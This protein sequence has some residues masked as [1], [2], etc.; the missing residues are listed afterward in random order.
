[1]VSVQMQIT[2]Q[3]LSGLIFMTLGLSMLWVRRSPNRTIFS[4][5]LYALHKK[6]SW[7]VSAETYLLI[8][9]LIFVCLGLFLLLFGLP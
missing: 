4:R 2:G 9:G 8:V 7:V 5:A 3:Q 1:M 6:T